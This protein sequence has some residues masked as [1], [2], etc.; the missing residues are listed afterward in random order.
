[1]YN[2]IDSFDIARDMYSSF[3]CIFEGSDNLSERQFERAL[4]RKLQHLHDVDSCS[5]NWDPSVSKDPLSD[6]FSFSLGGAA[7]FIIGLNPNS[8]RKSRQFDYP[9]VVFNLHSQFEEL[10]RKGKFNSVKDHIRRRDKKFSGSQNPMLA[11]HGDGS[12]IYQYSGRTVGK[13]WKCPFQAKS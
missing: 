11:T 8:C 5:H 1:M 4:W 13:S 3:V 2:F 10:R 9:A 7:F 6:D 12:E